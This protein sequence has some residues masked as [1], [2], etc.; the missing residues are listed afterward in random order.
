MGFDLL[1]MIV[2]MLKLEN[3]ISVIDDKWPLNGAEIEHYVKIRFTL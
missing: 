2:V 3:S 1:R